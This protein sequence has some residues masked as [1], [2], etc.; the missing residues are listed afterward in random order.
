MDGHFIHLTGLRITSPCKPVPISRSQGNW[1]QCCPISSSSYMNCA[2]ACCRKISFQK[3]LLPIHLSQM[4]CRPKGFSPLHPPNHSF[5]SWSQPHCRM[6]SSAPV[7]P[8]FPLLFLP[9]SLHQSNILQQRLPHLPSQELF[10][11]F[12][13]LI[14]GRCILGPSLHRQGN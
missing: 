6:K 2:Q 14:T 9:P 12:L 7:P 10:W 13:R 5:I 1:R 8:P 11:A 4:H 3:L